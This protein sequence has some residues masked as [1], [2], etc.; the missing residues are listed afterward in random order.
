MQKFSLLMLALCMSLSFSYAQSDSQEPS[1]NINELGIGFFRFGD[2][3]RV[4]YR[5]GKEDNLWRF[6]AVN[7][8]VQFTKYNDT[9]SNV[10]DQKDRQASFGF[11]VGK[12]YR[13]DI[14]KNFQLRY[15]YDLGYQYSYQNNF[16]EYEDFKNEY[17]AVSHTPLLNL[18]LG[19]NYSFNDKLV[20]GFETL[21]TFAY[22][23]TKT[24]SSYESFDFPENS[25]LRGQEINTFSFN[26]NSSSLLFTLA[27][28][29]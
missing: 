28:K 4:V 18:V 1:K 20:L 11:R 27:Y 24:I 5:T 12:E 2:G 14:D 17:E 10:I 15:G 16:D 8:N 21:P 19:L 13:T 9:T 7:G 25:Y 3:F 6:S 22:R 29:W 23:M 26:L